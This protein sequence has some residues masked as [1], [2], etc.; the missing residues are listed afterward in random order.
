MLHL[1]LAAIRFDTF[2]FQSLDSLADV[3]GSG[4][5]RAGT[6]RD[7]IKIIISFQRTINENRLKHLIWVFFFRISRSLRLSSTRYLARS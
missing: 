1:C 6:K 3:S 2:L 7:E 5:V 4:R